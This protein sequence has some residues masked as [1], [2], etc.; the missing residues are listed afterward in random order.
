MAVL[1][2]KTI[3]ALGEN[4]RGSAGGD[5]RNGWLRQCGVKAGQRK[6]QDTKNG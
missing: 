1:K 3:G 4:A 5:Y 6:Q 2:V